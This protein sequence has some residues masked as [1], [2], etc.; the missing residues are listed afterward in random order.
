MESKR[1]NVYITIFVITTIIAAG[2]AIF[3][4]VDGDNKLK[5]MEAK[6]EENLG[7][8]NGDEL[9]KSEVSTNSN[10]KDTKG[11][12][13]TETVEKIVKENVFYPDVDSSKCINKQDGINE[14]KKRISQELVPLRCIVNDDRK[15]A[16]LTTD[17]GY[18][19]K[20]WGFIP[21]GGNGLYEQH[22]SNGFGGEI[23]DVIS[24][25]WG[26]T[27]D[28]STLLFLMKDGTVEY[29][30]VYQAYKTATYNSRGKI[31]GVTDIVYIGNV[32]ANGHCEP[33]AMKKDGSFYL[34]SSILK[35][36]GNYF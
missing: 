27:S 23:V 7:A 20:A 31:P 17:W 16:T 28:Y 30:P 22:N 21:N 4:K 11:S 33:I 29:I 35:G 8:N 26:Q 2:L 6:V 24:T 36:T 34:L 14:Y 12:S 25:G 3:F 10:K 1:K 15:S 5:S 18:A 19:T 32:T 13:Q 9:V